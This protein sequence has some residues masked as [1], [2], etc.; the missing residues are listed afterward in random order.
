LPQALLSGEHAGPRSGH[1]A[2]RRTRPLA[3]REDRMARP[4]RVRMRSRKPWV[5]ARRR[6]FGWNVRLLTVESLPGYARTDTREHMVRRPPLTAT[7]KDT[8]RP[9]TGPNRSPGPAG[10]GICPAASTERPPCSRQATTW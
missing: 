5:F 6:L 3:R 9:P 4:A 8:R 2:E 1:Q 10:G 7:L